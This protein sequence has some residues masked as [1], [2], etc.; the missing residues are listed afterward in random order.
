MTPILA[1]RNSS[2]VKNYRII[3]HNLVPTTYSIT[4]IQG[5]RALTTNQTTPTRKLSS[6]KAARVCYTFPKL[7]FIRGFTGDRFNHPC[8]GLVANCDRIVICGG[9]W[10]FIGSTV[11]ITDDSWCRQ[12]MHAQQTKYRAQ[13]H[14]TR[15]SKYLL[16]M[17][18]EI[19]QD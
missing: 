16:F 7:K 8:T 5:H 1:C 3:I 2:C 4:N 14:G 15:I 11:Q 18:M 19:K 6:K 9:V 13:D 10:L 12:R 17:D